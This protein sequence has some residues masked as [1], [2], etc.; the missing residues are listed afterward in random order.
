M[1]ALGVVVLTPLLLPAVAHAQRGRPRG[2]GT[3]A[4]RLLV[5]PRV[6]DT[7]YLQVEQTVE[8][9]GRKVDGAQ[10]SVPPVL[11]GKRGASPAPEY[12]PRVNRANTRVTRVQLFAHSLVEASDL[13]ATTL[14]ATTDSIRMWAGNA[15]DP[16]RPMVVP[17]EEDTRYVRVKVTPDGAMRVSDP[18]TAL[19]L[20]ATLASVPGLL[21]D[22]P[23]SVGSEWMREMVLPSLPLGAYRADGVVQ[24]RL[25]LDSLTGGG[26]QAWI[27]V[28]GVL[29]RDGAAREL[30]T[31]TRVITAGTMRGTMVVD[32]TRAWITDARTVM[33]VQS[34]V[35]PGPAGAGT[36]MLLDIRIVQ[37]V[38]VR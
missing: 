30:P 15:G 29:R 26:R 19:P 32:R 14:L 4:V 17:V 36:P 24:A 1:G 7:L 23:I 8:V 3:E 18:P 31:G 13:S 10:S 38:R 16:V 12:G 33:D 28:S 6:G 5:R 25:R 22:G 27:S 34:E 21:P 35:A 11:Q 37:R 9:S 20:G 2:G